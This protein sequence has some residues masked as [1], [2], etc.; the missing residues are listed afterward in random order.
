MTKKFCMALCITVMITLSMIPSAAFA[1]TYELKIG[2]ES[3]P[4]SMQDK[5]A[6]KFKEYVEKESNEEI[7][8]SIFPSDQIGDPFALLQGVQ[9]GVVE[10]GIFNG[11]S[12]ATVLKEYALFS[13]PELLPKDQAKN[14]QI[15]A[16]G[17]EFVKK[18]TQETEKTGVKYL[19]AYIEPFFQLTANKNIEKAADFEGLKIRTMNS[20]IIIATYKALGANP[21]PI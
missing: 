20:P 2:H 9:S 21:T 10:L 7:T 8:V 16:Q 11:G 19:G 4:D 1:A 17:S 15:F 5:F 6:Q 12:I 18:L 3:A 13:I 14:R